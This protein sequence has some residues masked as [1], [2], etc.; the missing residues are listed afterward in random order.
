M[1][2]DL[3]RKGF[4]KDKIEKYTTGIEPGS[5]AWKL[6]LMTRTPNGLD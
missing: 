2:I 4:S 3:Q 6:K 1:Q 5:S